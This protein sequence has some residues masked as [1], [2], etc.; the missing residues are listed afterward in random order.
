MNFIHAVD[1]TEARGN[2]V[3]EE[4]EIAFF[5]RQS[6]ETLRRTT[7]HYINL[8]GAKYSTSSTRTAGKRPEIHRFTE[9]DRIW[10]T[11]GICLSGTLEI[12]RLPKESVSHRLPENGAKACSTDSVPKY[13]PVGLG[14]NSC[15]SQILYKSSRFAYHIEPSSRFFKPFPPPPPELPASVVLLKVQA[16]AVLV[17]GHRAHAAMPRPSRTPKRQQAQSTAV[18]H[19]ELQKLVDS[20]AGGA[21]GFDPQAD[22]QGKCGEGA[23]PGW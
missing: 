12:R 15:T 13:G 17:Q 6:P 3:N 21:D 23:T 20:T 10:G 2:S 4:I 1:G 19:R 22:P 7:T 18:A 14:C 8:P 11:S 9:P 5:L 16:I